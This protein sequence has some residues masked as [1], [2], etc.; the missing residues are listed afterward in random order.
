MQ[1][2]PKVEVEALFRIPQNPEMQKEL[3]RA[4]SVPIQAWG[5]CAG[6]RGYSLGITNLLAA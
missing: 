3:Q 6:G 4:L 2:R 1:F 5:R